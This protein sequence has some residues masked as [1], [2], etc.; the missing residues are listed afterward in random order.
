M[1]FNQNSRFNIFYSDLIVI[2]FSFLG[3]LFVSTIVLIS[4]TG[5]REEGMGYGVIAGF[6]FGLGVFYYLRGRFNFTWTLVQLIA[7]AGL[8]I[9]EFFGISFLVRDTGIEKISYGYV[10][11]FL[12]IPAVVSINKQALDAMM[13]KVGADKR[14]KKPF[15]VL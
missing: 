6:A 10:L 8:S 14:S 12:F 11:I 13:E 9:G 7:N 4:S 15:E 3:S 2:I 1:P 5:S